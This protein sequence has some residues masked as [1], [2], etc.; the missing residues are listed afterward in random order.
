MA[1]KKACYNILQSPLD[2]G[3]KNGGSRQEK[4]CFHAA[5]KALGL[6]GP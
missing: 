2:H 5:H 6:T 3:S 1:H 4:R